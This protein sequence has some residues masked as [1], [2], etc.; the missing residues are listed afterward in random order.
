M[1]YMKYVFGDSLGLAFFKQILANVI[2]WAKINGDFPHTLY[3]KIQI[4]IVK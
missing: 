4:K 2:W 3:D 1:K